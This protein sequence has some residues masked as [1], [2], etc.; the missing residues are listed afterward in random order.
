[1]SCFVGLIDSITSTAFLDFATSVASTLIGVGVAHI[2][3]LKLFLRE[4]RAKDKADHQKLL[5]QVENA[6]R[7]VGDL[8][9]T[10]V[11][12]LEALKYELGRGNIISNFSVGQ[13]PLMIHLQNL[14]DDKGGREIHAQIIGAS[15]SASTIEVT[16]KAL[17]A[18]NAS[19][20]EWVY[21][22]SPS[23]LDETVAQLHSA[24]DLCN[25]RAWFLHSQ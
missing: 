6:Y 10:A 14:N 22:I 11:E 15:I 9:L 12:P 5:S 16:A 18:R 2:L 17:F 8:L 21:S 25:Q 13:E 24:F 3:A 23:T 7:R 4:K 20:A 19:S 1:M